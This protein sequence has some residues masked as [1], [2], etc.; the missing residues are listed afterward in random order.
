MER[1]QSSRM[2]SGTLIFSLMAG[3]SIVYMDKNMI[4]TAIIPISEQYHLDSG[5]TGIIMSAFFL[6]YSLM[7]IPSGWLADK[8]GAK[9]VLMA[10]MAIIGVFSYLFGIANGLAFFIAVRFFAGMGHG[11]YPPSC[12]KSIAENFPQERRTFVQSLILSTSGIGGI[13]AFT[14]GANLISANWH[15]AYGVLGTLYL[16]ACLCILIFVPSKPREPN[17]DT[18]PG[19]KKVGFLEVLKNRNV[20]VLFLA[21]LLLNILLYGN[22]SWM[23]TYIKTTFHLSISQTGLLLA[24]NAIFSTAATIYAGQL[25]SKVFLGREKMAIIG[26]TVLSALL[27]I[28]FVYS[29]NLWISLVLLIMVSCVSVVAFTG[30]FTWPHKIMDPRIIGSSI[31]VVNTGGTLGGFLAPMIIGFLVKAAGGSFVWAFTFMAAASIAA[32]LMVLLVKAPKT[33]A[34]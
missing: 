8:L 5:Q 14:L 29:K 26:A 22:I 28:G 33:A 6:G 3:Y 19:E 25:L 15:L 27:V 9:R 21:M 23:P 1:K 18:A 20:L 4:S 32:G 31:G 12:S 10:S 17:V 30:I 24:V 16:L 34:K 13:L 7:Q 2:A 11:G